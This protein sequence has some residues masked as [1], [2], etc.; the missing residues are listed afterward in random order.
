M[1]RLTIA[2]YYTPSGRSIQ[3]P[4]SEGYDKYMENFLKRY[5]DGEMLTADSTHFPDSLKYK[6]LVNNRVVYGGGGIMPDVFIAVDTSYNSLYFRRL[7]GKNVLNSWVL[8]YFDK[9]RALLASQYKS[10]DEF[11]KKFQFNPEEIKNFIAKGETEGVKYNEEQFNISKEELLL[12]LKGLVATNIWQTTQYYQIINENDKV[13][14][15]ALKVISDK[16][17]YN[18]LLGNQ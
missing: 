11:N 3:S 17:S 8:E 13:I 5:T 12:V 18:S 7:V 6:T 16:K 14:E 1:I 15:K 2:R 4:Y 10:F 9:N